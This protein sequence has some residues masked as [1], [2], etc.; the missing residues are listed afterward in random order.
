MRAM[1][2]TRQVHHD[3]KRDDVI[4]LDDVPAFGVQLRFAKRVPQDMLT[5]FRHRRHSSASPDRS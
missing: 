3:V 5:Q 2:T 4:P 1:P